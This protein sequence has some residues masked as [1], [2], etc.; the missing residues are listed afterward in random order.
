MKKSLTKLF[1]LLAFFLFLGAGTSHADY[2]LRNAESGWNSNDKYYKFIEYDK[3]GDATRYKLEIIDLKPGYFD[4][5]ENDLKFGVKKDNTKTVNLDTETYYAKGDQNSGDAAEF[6]GA[7]GHVNVFLTVYDNGYTLKIRV[8]KAVDRIYYLTG[9]KLNNWNKTDSN[10]KF[11]PIEKDGDFN[12]YSLDIRNVPAGQ[13][14]IWANNEK[15]GYKKTNTQILEIN[16]ETYGAKYVKNDDEYE[17]VF[18]VNDDLGPAEIILTE[19]DNGHTLKVK[20]EK[21]EIIADPV[22]SFSLYGDLNNWNEN[23]GLPMDKLSENQ[24]IIRNV[25]MPKEN[26]YFKF[27]G[28][29]KDYWAPGASDIPVNVREEFDLKLGKADGAYKIGAGTYTILV[30]LSNN[31]EAKV[32]VYPQ[33]M[34]IYGNINDWYW[35]PKVYVTMNMKEDQPGVYFA[36]EVEFSGQWDSYAASQGDNRKEGDST[37]DENYV[38]FFDQIVSNFDG[39]KYAY[40]PSSDNNL[41]I[42]DATNATVK[43][44]SAG[45]G[46]FKVHKA[47]YDVTFDLNEMK[48]AWAIPQ[49]EGQVVKE[50]TYNWWFGSDQV[51]GKAKAELITSTTNDAENVNGK[52]DD[53]AYYTFKY[54]DTEKNIIQAGID[55]NPMHLLAK[56]VEYKVW[57]RNPADRPAPVAMSSARRAGE[58][59]SYNPGDAV[60]SID[61]LPEGF[62]EATPYNEYDPE[63]TRSYNDNYHIVLNKAGDYVV[64]A[65]IDVEDKNVDTN[66]FK[67]EVT[68]T[69]LFVTVAEGELTLTTAADSEATSSALKVPFSTEGEN[70]FES[71]FAFEGTDDDLTKDTDFT[72]S[73]APAGDASGWTTP[74]NPSNIQASYEEDLNVPGSTL[75][76]QYLNLNTSVVDGYYLPLTSESY[77][78]EQSD[79]SSNNFN[80]TL[81]A[82]CSG[83][84]DLTISPVTGS[85]YTFEE[86][87]IQLTVYPNLT[88]KFG[89]TTG[90]NIYGYPVVESTVEIPTVVINQLG[91]LTAPEG[92][93]KYIENV[94]AFIPGT[95]FANE[96]KQVAEADASLNG[97]IKPMGVARRADTNENAENYVTGI[98]LSSLYGTN[99]KTSTPVKIYV[100]KNGASNTY[101]FTVATTESTLGVETIGSEADGEVIYYNMQGVRVEN[102]EHGIFVKVQNGKS[103]KIIL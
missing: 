93:N 74:S 56:Q 12:R 28:N 25:E 34:Y 59:G 18:L 58:S 24:W 94:T 84:Y 67:Y 26:N 79:V 19:Y 15:F 53:N 97:G 54:G 63:G 82:P 102:P 44:V 47:L 31:E 95:Y 92:T 10:C 48:A 27:I 46:N 73:V 11:I 32:R 66:G 60:Q 9:D 91:G 3:D 5:Y 7:L 101:D 30:T 36:E 39:Y 52:Y 86:Q 51:E 33:N 42:N 80:V 2:Y 55:N 50:R 75:Y 14:E 22:T 13:Y 87:T 62:V 88:D 6:A 37:G 23:S 78:A 1:A 40:S 61:Q 70:I 72:I 100:E 20:V 64:T 43:Y 99:A 29:G 17:G 21:G 35:D 98:D 96:F 49:N 90:F 69:S 57:Y 16:K 76:Q 68:P 45:G 71:I 4:I 103:E 85:N 89:E 38:A 65:N 77:D 41:E 83:V 8:E 81:K